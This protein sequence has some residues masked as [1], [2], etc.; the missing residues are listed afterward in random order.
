VV[1]NQVGVSLEGPNSCVS[2]ISQGMVRPDFPRMWVRV[3]TA[4][5][6][7]AWAT[8]AVFFLPTLLF[9]YNMNAHSYGVV[10]G[11]FFIM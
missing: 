9:I 7:K 3:S 1:F 11:C 10:G 4:V 2:L 6:Q 8:A 5:A